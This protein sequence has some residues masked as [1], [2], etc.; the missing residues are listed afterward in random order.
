MQFGYET[1]P[2][3][4]ARANARAQ[5]LGWSAGRGLGDGVDA[6]S[7]CRRPGGR[8]F[9]MGGVGRLGAGPLAGPS[10]PQSTRTGDGCPERL[11]PRNRDPAG[12]S[13]ADGPVP[14]LLGDS[15]SILMQEIPGDDCYSAK[16]P[17]LLRM[18]GLL[19]ELQRV[20][21]GG[22]RTCVEQAFGLAGRRLGPAIE[23]VVARNAEGLKQDDRLTLEQFA[24]GFPGRS[25][26]WRHKASRH[27]GA[28]RLPSRQ[29]AGRR[30]WPSPAGLGDSG[31]QHLSSTSRPSSSALRAKWSRCCSA[32]R[33]GAE[34][35]RIGPSPGCCLAR[36]G[37]RRPA[38]D[39]LPG[40]IRPH[41]AVGAPHHQADPIDWLQRA[42][43]LIRAGG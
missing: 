1:D 36:A 19:V 32:A 37:R 24:A 38:G 2:T 13:L 25:R 11:L 9:A 41:R 34:R 18:I 23:A 10:D 40:A 43:M 5:A 7:G 15:T 6:G 3:G 29:R 12:K 27:P 16:P 17:D 26:N 8:F 22:S 35:G 20:W 4:G 42:A 39:D 31:I 33:R 28:G 30:K 21:A 14:K